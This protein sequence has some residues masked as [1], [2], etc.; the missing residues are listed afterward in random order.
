MKTNQLKITYQKTGDLVPYARNSRTHSEEQVAQIAGSIREFGFT[1]PVLVDE[2]NTIIAGHGR[3]MAAQKL[4]LEDVP[5]ITLAGL[6]ESQRKAYII[7]DNRLAL[8][9]GWDDEML[10]LEIADLKEDGFDLDLL[11]FEDDELD[12]LEVDI[13]EG[14]TDP[15]EVPEPPADPVT[16]LGDVWTLGNHRLMCGDSTSIDAVNK[17]MDGRKA[18]CLWTDPPY[19]VS[20]VGKTKDALTIQNDSLDDNSLTEFLR[21]AFFTAILATEAGAAWYVAAPAGPLHQCFSVVLKELGVWRQT[22]NWIK[23]SMVM[24]RSDYHYQHEPIFYGWNPSGSHKWTSDR[25]QTTV[26][27][28]DKPNRNGEH[29]TMKPIELVEYCIGNN[30]NKGDLVLDLFGGSGTTMMASEKSGRISRLMELA[31]NYCDVIVKRWQDFTGKKAVHESGKTFEE[32]AK[33]RGK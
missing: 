6:T 16:V 27:N 25:K 24:G 28:F 4:G 5:T 29:P 31:P 17:L 9:A 32:M 14:Q 12:A 33:S 15:D 10:R 19:G 7:A 8:N 18:S 3:I 13:V 20:Y 22:L 30:T 21:E 2:R 1:N 11:G 23:S 26:L